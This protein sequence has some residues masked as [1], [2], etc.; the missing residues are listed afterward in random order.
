H[1][2]VPGGADVEAFH[3]HAE[4]DESPHEKAERFAAGENTFC[5]LARFRREDTARRSDCFVNEPAKGI[6]MCI[7]RPDLFGGGKAELVAAGAD[8]LWQPSSHAFAEAAFGP[9]A[10]PLEFLRQAETEVHE[11]VIQ[12]RHS[13]L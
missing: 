4:T 2:S 10:R 3:P 6:T 1:S 11:A 8:P 5:F 9:A 13:S 7:S 12:G